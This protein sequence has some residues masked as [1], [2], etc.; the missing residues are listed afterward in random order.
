MK[1]TST[2]TRS[3]AQSQETYARTVPGSIVY[4]LY[5]SHEVPTPR[6]NDISKVREIIADTCAR[7][8][9]GASIYATIG[10]WKGAREHSTVI[11]IIARAPLN[12][13]PYARLAGALRRQFDQTAVLITWGPIDT[14]EVHA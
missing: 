8:T 11:E 3:L 12:L 7:Y 14:L 13:E 6:T 10:L 4:R 9:D 2:L 1:Q 5:L